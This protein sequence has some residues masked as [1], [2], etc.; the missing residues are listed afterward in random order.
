MESVKW[1][2]ACIYCMVL[3]KGG[4]HYEQFSYMYKRKKTESQR[5]RRGKGRPC[6]PLNTPTFITETGLFC[7][8]TGLYKLRGTL[9]CIFTMWIK[10]WGIVLLRI[11]A[12]KSSYQFPS[13]NIILLV[14]DL[15]WGCCSFVSF[16]YY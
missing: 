11:R 5:E 3:P 13:F 8:Q 12:H 15:K 9:S 4:S 2:V 14:I 10:N 1:M 6:L 16:L 7:Q